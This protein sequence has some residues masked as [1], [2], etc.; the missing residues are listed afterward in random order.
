MKRLSLGLSFMVILTASVYSNNHKNTKETQSV[1]HIGKYIGTECREDFPGVRIYWAPA[2]EITKENNNYIQTDFHIECKAGKDGK[3]VPFRFLDGYD[4][5]YNPTN[6]KLSIEG[7]YF[8][9]ANQKDLYI[10][11]SDGKKLWGLLSEDYIKKIQK[12]LQSGVKIPK[13]RRK[14]LEESLM[15]K[16]ILLMVRVNEN[17]KLLN[18]AFQECS[19]KIQNSK[20]K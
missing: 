19:I 13:E 3:Y 10:F 4:G 1:I 7:K 20:V 18:K 12:Y 5:T 17:D 2:S 8:K 15:A 14:L 16:K 6:V 9:T 11:S